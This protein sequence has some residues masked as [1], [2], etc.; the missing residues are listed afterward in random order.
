MTGNALDVVKC[1]TNDLYVPANA[2]IVLEG[3]L[4]ITET[5]PGTLP[6]SSIVILRMWGYSNLAHRGS[7]W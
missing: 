1:E 3:T 7:I 6:Y 5:G 4:S 2:E